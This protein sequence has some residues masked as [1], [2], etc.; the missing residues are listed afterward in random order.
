MNFEDS[1]N[2]L[3]SYFETLCVEKILK[4]VNNIPT[5]DPQQLCMYLQASE[6]IKQE[7][8]FLA[9]VFISVIKYQ[10]PTISTDNLQ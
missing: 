8:S 2:T 1:I 10:S 7:V 4:N 6:I 9:V 5:R 3:I